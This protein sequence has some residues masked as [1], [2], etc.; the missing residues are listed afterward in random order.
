MGSLGIGM[1]C[2]L[3][4]RRMVIF[5]LQPRFSRAD[6]K[7]YHDTHYSEAFGDDIGA[8]AQLGILGKLDTCL[9]GT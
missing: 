9:A 4:T 2:L 6:G 1:A 3:A 8:W 7:L 5:G